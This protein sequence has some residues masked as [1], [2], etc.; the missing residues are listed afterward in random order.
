MT[1]EDERN[2]FTATMSA[3][4][5]TAVKRHP[6]NGQPKASDW[7]G[8]YGVGESREETST[9]ASENEVDRKSSIYRAKTTIVRRTTIASPRMTKKTASL[10][11]SMKKKMMKKNASLK[12]FI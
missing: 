3:I 2:S 11:T 9:T 7:V 1:E 5:C 12:I 4:P 6:T 8:D 10:R